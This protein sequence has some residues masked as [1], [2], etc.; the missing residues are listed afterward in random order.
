MSPDNLT[1][2]FSLG[3]GKIVTIASL[4]NG[5]HVRAQLINYFIINEDN[6]FFSILNLRIKEVNINM[7]FQTPKIRK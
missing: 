4:F 1:P 7:Y 3:S 6:I 2:I 5:F